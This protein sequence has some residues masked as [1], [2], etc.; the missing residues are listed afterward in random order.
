[1]Y[2]SACPLQFNKNHLKACALLSLTETQKLLSPL[3][4]SWASDTCQSFCKAS[5][6]ESVP[7]A[8]FLHLQSP[9]TDSSIY[10]NTLLPKS[11]KNV[12]SE[13][14]KEQAPIPNAQTLSCPSLIH[15]PAEFRLPKSPSTK[16]DTCLWWLPWHYRILRFYPMPPMPHCHCHRLVSSV[17]TLKL[18]AFTKVP[19]LTA[20]LQIWELGQR[21]GLG[22]Q[23][24]TCH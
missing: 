19:T 8:W 3:T 10:M 24:L 1:M 12:L 20:T 9:V 4:P 14:T 5:L 7:S 15:P 17:D 6:L 13:D 18:W 16:G 2:F 11:T 22:E 21:C 23:C